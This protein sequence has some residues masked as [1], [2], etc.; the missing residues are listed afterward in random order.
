MIFF[1]GNFRYFFFLIK[2]FFSHSRV[3]REYFLEYFI[4]LYITLGSLE[5]ALY[6]GLQLVKILFST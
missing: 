2:N 4:L 6:Q 3:L 1:G 5:M